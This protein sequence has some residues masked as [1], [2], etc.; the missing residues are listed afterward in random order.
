MNG[1][2]NMKKTVTKV[3]SLVLVFVLALSTLAACGGSKKQI[4]IYTSVEDYRM[5]YLQKR[6]NE[7]FPDYNIVMEYKS[8][9]EH[10]AILK[11]SGK[12]VACDISYNIEYGHAQEIAEL[13]TFANLEGVVDFSVFENDMVE[14]TY[15][16]PQER[17]GGAIIINK[18]VISKKG[19]DIPETYEDLLDPQYKGLISMPSP[20]SSGTG[21]M[22]L[23][24]L[25][26]EWGEDKAFEYFDKLSENVLQFTTSGSGPVNALVSGEV[27]IG[28]GMTSHATSKINEG[29]SLEI[30]FF[31]EGSPYTVYGQ[32]VIAGKETDEAV[33][34]VFEFL[35]GTLTEENNELFYPEKLFKDKTV[36]L[37]NFPENI[38]YSNM[39][40]NTFARKGE[41]LAKWKH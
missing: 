9:G 15:Y 19:L 6:L 33:M 22:F 23:L 14:S 16:L 37:E 25:V 11:A 30:M 41:L 40:N 13:G 31:E 35:S 39:S 27:A 3:L 8:S 17:S 32:A 38:K 36:T 29:S 1:E 26:N 12:D 24:T 5:E 28:F 20:A 10:A 4:V 2:K 7:Q 34:E 18:D 21:Y